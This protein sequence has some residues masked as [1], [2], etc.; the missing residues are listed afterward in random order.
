MKRLLVYSIFSFSGAIIALIIIIFGL[1]LERHF[2]A[3]Q[4]QFFQQDL[5]TLVFLESNVWDFP[6]TTGLMGETL[7]RENIPK[8]DSVKNIPLFNIVKKK[9]ASC[10]DVI[11]L[12]NVVITDLINELCILNEIKLSVETRSSRILVLL[13]HG[14][15]ASVA[16]FMMKPVSGGFIHE[17]RSS[18]AHCFLVLLQ[19]TQKPTEH[20]NTLHPNPYNLLCA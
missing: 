19:T 3:C 5:A 14:C 12:F 2:W 11:Q 1:V 10:S 20:S 4:T 18:E 15:H 17:S 7:V 6:K 9:V 13:Y 16:A 8:K